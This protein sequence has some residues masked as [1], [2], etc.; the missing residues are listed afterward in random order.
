ME[1]A[2]VSKWLCRGATHSYVFVFST[3]TQD[4]QICLLFF[5]LSKKG[6]RVV[7]F[8]IN[9]P[10]NIHSNRSHRITLQLQR[11][12]TVNFILLQVARFAIFGKKRTQNRLFFFLSSMWILCQWNREKRQRRYIWLNRATGDLESKSKWGVEGR[13]TDRDRE[14]ERE[15]QQHT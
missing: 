8:Y 9:K 1:N 4:T 10:L 14:R 2:G 12:K 13:Q 5:F 15:K 6:Y 3:N 11:H 7:N